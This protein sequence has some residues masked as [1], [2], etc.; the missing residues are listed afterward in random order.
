M[1]VLP[2][3]APPSTEQDQSPEHQAL[4]RF[5]REFKELCDRSHKQLRDRWDGYYELYRGYVKLKK[6]YNRD[7]DN[8][9]I[10]DA[11]R[12]WGARLHI[13][14]VFATVETVV[15]RALS[16]DPVMRALPFTPEAKQSAM[17][18]AKIFERDQKRIGYELKLQ[19]TARRG[20]TYGLGVQKTYW[21]RKARKQRVTVPRKYLR[22]YAVEERTEVLYEGPQ[23][24]SVDNFDF[25]WHP[26]GKDMSTVE[27][28]LHRTWRSFKYVRQMIE[29]GTW[30]PVDLDAVRRTMSEAGFTEAWSSRRTAAGIDGNQDVGPRCEVWEY[31]DGARVVTIL[32]GTFVVQDAEN[33]AYHGEIPFQIFRPTQVPGEFCGIGEIEMIQQLQHE[34]DTMRSQRR[35]NA[36]VVLNKGGFYT[37]GFIDPADLKSGPGVWT[38]V[39]GNPREAMMEFNWGDIPASGYQEEAALKSDIERVTGMSDPIMG[40]DAGG[41]STGAETATGIQLIQNASNVRVALKAKNLLRETVRPA[42]CQWLALYKQHWLEAQTVRVE[43]PQSTDG[44]NFIELAPEDFQQ[45]EDVE[46]EAGSTE[47]DNPVAKQETA[48]RLFNQL[49]GNPVVDPRKL[50]AYYLREHDVKDAEGFLVPP[51]PTREEAVQEAITTIGTALQQAGVPEE[52][53]EAAIQA[54]ANVTPQLEEPEQE[55]IPSG[56]S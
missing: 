13:P 21:Q 42:A 31:H 24:E 38:P 47:P 23:A 53:I 18:V 45:I 12:E 27:G 11:Q 6:A 55:G 28:V 44:Y 14:Y 50:A 20:F 32:N 9:V 7:Q 33:P 29:S 17:A 34:L 37:E 49:N 15:P 51:G 2:A 1:P 10:L 26:A 36:T 54:S 22:G 46:P 35:D 48:M 3:L 43:D 8:A 4:L 56:S 16:N 25:F 19:E 41:A 39:L 52:L 30:M 40:G 5:V